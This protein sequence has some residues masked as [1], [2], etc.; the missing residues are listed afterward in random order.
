MA[1][2]QM[3]RETTELEA[4]LR[5]RLRG[6]VRFDRMTR[7]IYA[8]DASIYQMDPIG[9]VF[10]MDVE[11]VV[12]TVTFAGSQ[13]VPVLPRGGG[14]GLAGQTVNHA[15]VMDFS[16]HMNQLIEMNPEEGWAWV[17]PGIVL[18][19]LS[20]LG[21]PPRPQVRAGPVD[22]QPW[23]HRRRHRQQLLRRPLH[24]V[25]QDPRPRP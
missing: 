5:R 4:E 10:P 14:T 13:G 22:H 2:R 3:V 16:R 21:A 12:N 25:R 15:I 6:E 23:Q 19:Q 17:Q 7:A 24:R 18:D 1:T 9:V 8:T 20:A 11:D